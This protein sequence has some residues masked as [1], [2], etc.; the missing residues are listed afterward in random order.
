MEE[1]FAKAKTRDYL[2]EAERERW[3]ADAR[4]KGIEISGPVGRAVRTAIGRLAGVLGILALLA[5]YE[6]MPQ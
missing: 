1:V 2:M 3:L 6:G 4:S 5:L